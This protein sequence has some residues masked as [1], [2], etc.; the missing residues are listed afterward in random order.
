MCVCVYV[1]IVTNAQTCMGTDSHP[2][3]Y[4]CTYVLMLYIC[5]YTYVLFFKR[6]NQN[7][8]KLSDIR[9]CRNRDETWASV[10]LEFLLW[11]NVNVLCN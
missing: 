6:T 3:I 11:S 10:F 8:Q 1:S 9:G 4:T 5:I 2:P 7:Y